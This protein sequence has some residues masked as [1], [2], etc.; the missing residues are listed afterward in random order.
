MSGKE[1]SVTGG[2]TLPPDDDAQSNAPLL[3]K[4]KDFLNRYSPTHNETADTLDERYSIDLAMALPELDA[5]N[6]KAFVA[7]DNME[8]S[9]LIY[10]HVCEPGK[11]Q[12]Y[13]AITLLKG[14]ENRYIVQL[15]AAGTVT[16]SSNN[17]ERFVIF[18][19]RPAGIKLSELMKR[20]RI[21]ANQAFII[22][23][24]LLPLGNVIAAF[25]EL[26]ISHGL[27]NPDNIF[28]SDTAMLGPCVAEPCGYSQ[29]YFYESVER[30]QALPAAKGEGSAA[31]D[32][33]ALAV[34]LLY[35]LHGPEH[36]EKYTKDG[37]TRSLLKHGAYHALMQEKEVAEV[38]YDF[39]RGTLTI[40]AEERWNSKQVLP[41]LS[42]KRYNVLPPP[43]PVDAV[44]P[45]EFGEQLASTRRELAHLFAKDWEHMIA[46]LQN[47]QL[48]HWVSVSLRNKE[49]SDIVT[50]LSRT[51]YDLSTKNDPHVNDSL[52]NIVMLL[53]P[54]GPIRIKHISMHV[55][56]L[57]TLCAELYVNKANPEL[58]MLAK[59]IE[60]NMVNYWLELQQ[61]LH[62]NEFKVPPIINSLNIKLDRLRGTIRN[63]GFGFGL[64]RML[65]DLNPEMPC[66]SPV[67]AGK[68]VTSLTELLIKLDKIAPTLSDDEDPMD[69]HIAA[70]IA[71][72][73][74]IQHEIRLHDL[75]SIPVLA[76]NRTMI[77]LYLLAMAQ[78]RADPVRVPG[79]SHWVILRLLP[80]LSHIHSRT[81]R[82]KLKNVL[83]SY[84]PLGYLPK[85][86]ELL[87]TASHLNDDH[88]GFQQALLTFRENTI[89]IDNFQRAENIEY[90]SIN[91]GFNIARMVAYIC[92]AG[93]FFLVMR[94]GI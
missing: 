83:M 18:Y 22:E 7:S 64:E 49:L 19:E 60:A 15:L 27:V 86:A 72:K 54:T 85:I 3:Q 87:V 42:G 28:I 55:D 12:R 73:L 36:F 35:I 84:A 17:E 5:S 26:D 13:R 4:L 81:L 46:A 34:T 11:T 25:S 29:P 61:K 62:K 32:Y 79:L 41:W 30:I 80:L 77:A 40:G 47:N 56:G 71:S 70:Y 33:Y 59:F 2:A 90:D 20:K 24:I 44:R 69:R 57:D 52:M 58:Q 39:F 89:A 92:V 66:I 76:S 65:Y 75:A 9:K 43:P 91:M 53:D 31:Q 6:A 78:E 21:P 8:P 74:V 14:L 93:S 10:A 23:H 88:E 94:L 51:A 67:L 82:Q 38:F 1:K 68:H 48:S 63:T 37:F 45:F 16:L 50:R